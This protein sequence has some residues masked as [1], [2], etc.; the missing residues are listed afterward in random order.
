MTKFSMP[1]PVAWAAD[2]LNS[3]GQTRLDEK[4]RKP[5]LKE[6]PAHQGMP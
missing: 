3:L 2:A 6:F 1:F 5:L 4:S